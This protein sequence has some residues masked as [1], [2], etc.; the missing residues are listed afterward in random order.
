MRVFMTQFVFILINIAHSPGVGRITVT[1]QQL[2]MEVHRVV[3]VQKPECFEFKLLETSA[4]I[5][6]VI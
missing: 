1:G 2:T 3:V 5:V 4:W 6:I